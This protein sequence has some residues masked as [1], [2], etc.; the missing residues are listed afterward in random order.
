[1]SSNLAIV[2]TALVSILFASIGILYSKRKNFNI[3][4]FLVARGSAST[5][6][7]PA[8]ISASVIGAWVLFSPA[9]A[10]TWAGLTSLIGYGIGQASPLICFAILGPRLKNLIPEGHSILEYAWHRYGKYTYLICALVTI[11]YLF[12]FL[13]AELTAISSALNEISDVPLII[14]AIVIGGFTAIYT[15]YGGMRAS[16]ITDSIQFTLIVP[17]VVIIFVA[18]LSNLGGITDSINVV[19]QNRPELLSLS[20]GPGIEFGIT[21][22]FAVFSA[23]MFHQGFWQ[24]IY[25]AKNNRAIKIGFVSSAIIVIPIILMTG[26]IGIIA[27]GRATEGT[28]SVAFFNLSKEILPEGFIIALLILAIALVMS[29]LDT[30][31]NGITSAITTDISRM[32]PNLKPN[33]LLKYAR[34]STIILMIPAIIVAS[35]GYSV[36]YL[37]LVADL[38][39][40]AAVVPVFYGLYSRKI[41]DKNAS[42]SFIIGLVIGAIFFPTPAAGYSTTWLPDS[43]L[44]LPFQIPLSGKMLVSFSIALV[45]SGILSWILSYRNQKNKYEFSQLNKNINQF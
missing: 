24:R 40:S 1:M 20:H 37:F 8:T 26:L 19:T 12:V 13:T 33:I 28:P 43:I 9:E 31:L 11:S 25:S 21:L 23:N 16:I 4:D 27:S 6:V 7:T 36:L 5:P 29:S 3:E 34:I 14:T 30:L 35:Q 42:I 22:I 15:A 17:L 2:T 44:G 18:L 32:K 45:I 41:T 39:C 10:G 38:I